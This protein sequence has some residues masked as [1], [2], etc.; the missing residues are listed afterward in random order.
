MAELST[1]FACLRGVGNDAVTTNT[2]VKCLVLWYST[3]LKEIDEEPPTAI[4]AVFEHENNFKDFVRS[5]D[6][7]LYDY[8]A[9]KEL[10]AHGLNMWKRCHLPKSL[11]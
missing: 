6:H 8:V 5:R 11:R 7:K 9:A 10:W 1:Y 4:E 2:A 3:Y